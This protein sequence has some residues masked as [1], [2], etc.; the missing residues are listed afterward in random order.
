MKESQQTNITKPTIAQPENPV[1]APRVEQPPVNHLYEYRL[2]QLEESLDKLQQD[3][4]NQQQAVLGFAKDAQETA[5]YYVGNY[6]TVVT[7]LISIVGVISWLLAQ[8]YIKDK[9]DQLFEERMQ[10]QLDKRLKEYDEK[11]EETNKITKDIQKDAKENF[12]LLFAEARSEIDRLKQTSENK[13][14]VGEINKFQPQTEQEKNAEF[15]FNRAAIYFHQNNYDKA[16]E[17]YDKAIELN[18]DDAD[19]YNNRGVVYDKQQN[20]DKAIKDYDKAIELNPND[21]EAYTNRGN[22]YYEQKNYDKAIENYDKAIDINPNYAKAYNNRGVAYHAQQNYDKAI[23]NYD[24]AIDVNPNDADAYFNKACTYAK[25]SDGEVAEN[26]VE[27]IKYLSKAINLD[28]NLKELAKNE[29]DFSSL[30]NL[31]DFAELVN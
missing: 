7:L 9:V 24:K 2:E 26:Q 1:I 19:A 4:T 17:N 11:I 3:N 5:T 29:D 30:R 23:E 15:Y 8:K 18:P 28:K 6:L 16:I 27:A 12:G 21:C 14:F 10:K 31:P 25:K 22:S 13:N 20:Y